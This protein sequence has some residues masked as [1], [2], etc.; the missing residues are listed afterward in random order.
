MSTL[1]KTPRIEVVDA[2]RGFAIFSI[3]LLH[4]LEHFDY[5]YF[6]EQLPQWMKA[7][8][9]KIWETMFFLFSGKS[10]AIFSLLFGLTFFIQ[11]NNQQ[12]KGNDFNG[13]FIWRM[14]LLLLFGIINS[15][16]YEGDILTF[17]AIIG[18]VLVPV[19]HLSN[20]IVFVIALIFMVQPVELGKLVYILCNP[21]Y[22][23]PD[24]ASNMYFAQIGQ[25]LGGGT[26]I[27]AIKGNITNGKTAVV[28]WVWE[29][30]RV[31][32]TAGLF[33]FGLIL[34]RT[35]K[36]V[37]SD[38]NHKFWSK[39]LV[40]SIVAFLVLNILKGAFPGIFKSEPLVVEAQLIVGLWA[41]FAF[42]LIWVAL[43][44]VLFQ[45]IAANKL[46]NVFSPMGRMSMSNYVMQSVIGAFVYYGFGFGLY[47]YTGATYS[48][49]IGFCLFI[50]QLLFCRWWLQ[51]HKHGPLEYIW[52]K[53]TWLG[54]K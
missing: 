31:F 9:G 22:V 2:L 7:L 29:N 16:F 3:M 10:Y 12:K 4:N 13:R 52:H 33:M 38:E 47:K 27:E 24:K 21:D 48:L 35:N 50:L 14:F 45:K 8:D 15:L 36:F 30:G 6:P 19:R 11:F 28:Y 43:I 5:W 39:T 18:I 40:Y 1:S 20:T 41:N 51:K 42:M 26:F 53:A 49:V 34:G 54:T 46:L 44:V 25:Y 37:S 23:L 17:Y 32:Q